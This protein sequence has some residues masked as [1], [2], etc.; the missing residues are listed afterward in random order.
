MYKKNH[1]TSDLVSQFVEKEQMN[2][3]R[4]DVILKLNFKF[5]YRIV[6][7]L[8]PTDVLISKKIQAKYLVDNDGFI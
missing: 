1:K 6:V 7:F 4:I 3:K 5:L 2:L 8:D